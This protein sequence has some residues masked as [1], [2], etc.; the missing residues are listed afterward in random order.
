MAFSGPCV[1]CTEL[2]Q[3]TS[4]TNSFAQADSS[5]FSARTRAHLWEL[6]GQYLAL[7]ERHRH[8]A[9][10]HAELVRVGRGKPFLV[11]NQPI[12]WMALGERDKV[13]IDAAS[14]LEGILK[15]GGLLS[16]YLRDDDLAALRRPWGDA[17]GSVDEWRQA[18]FQRLFPSAA[19]ALRELP[20]PEDVVELAKLIRKAFDG[21]L[22]DRSR[23]RA[24]IYERTQ[25][26]APKML[27]PADVLHYI[28]RIHQVLADLHCLSAANYHPINDTTPD[29]RCLTARDVVDLLLLGNL[30]WIVDG[31]AG[32]GHAPELRRYRERREAHYDRLHAAHD[33][34]GDP[35]KA[36]NDPGFCA[37][38]PAP[39]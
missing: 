25:N 30:A 29:P 39:R 11:Q 9:S 5:R 21:L 6:G 13:V 2:R 34:A 1:G 22:R 23:H 12:L 32:T 17:V 35:D 20:I 14:W 4:V 37:V 16:D 19:A 36:S 27:A 10:V 38:M 33:E 26:G 7:S 18:A 3:G 31:P 24:H 8:V 15:A 28:D